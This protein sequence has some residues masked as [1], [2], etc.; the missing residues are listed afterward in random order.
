MKYFNSYTYAYIAVLDNRV[1]QDE[2][3]SIQ[4]IKHKLDYIDGRGYI[5]LIV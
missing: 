5:F 1:T 2:I 3:V 4:G